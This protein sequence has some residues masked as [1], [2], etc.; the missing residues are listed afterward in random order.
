M[1]TLRIALIGDQSPAVKAHSAIPSALRLASNPRQL[2]VAET[3]FSTSTLSDEVEGHLRGFHGVWCVPGSPYH[4]IEGALR[5]I[6]FARERQVPFLGTCGGS[7]HAIIEYCRNVLGC[8]HADHAES[9]PA[10][11]FPLIA[12]LPC[13]LRETESRIHLTP[14]SRARAIYGM[15]EI[16]EPFNCGFGLNP[17]HHHLFLKTALRITGSGEDGIA[18]V[19]ELDRHPFFI[20]TLFQPERSA[21]KNR[22]H[23]LIMAFV[24]AAAV[25]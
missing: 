21:F 12:P 5:A 18:R 23:P 7:Q 14:G 10:T 4:N 19:V 11:S 9:N 20:A 8:N 15:A 1:S 3:W 6:R 25:V 22:P 24:Q 13:A 16:S 2:A 17:E